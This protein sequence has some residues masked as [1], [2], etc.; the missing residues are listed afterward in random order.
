[1]RGTQKLKAILQGNENEY[2]KPLIMK[3]Y[4]VYFS[5]GFLEEVKNDIKVYEK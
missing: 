3:K 5:Y 4:T 2:D 1:V